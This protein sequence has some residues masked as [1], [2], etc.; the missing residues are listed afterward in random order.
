MVAILQCRAP[1]GPA[2]SQT[3]G[4][5]ECRVNGIEVALSVSVKKGLMPESIARVYRKGSV[6]LGR[7]W[8]WLSGPTNHLHRARGSD[9]RACDRFI[10][11]PS[12]LGTA[13]TLRARGPD[14]NL[15]MVRKFEAG[16]IK[17]ET[18]RRGVGFNTKD[19]P[20]N[21][22]RSRIPEGRSIQE[23]TRALALTRIETVLT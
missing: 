7:W 18:M 15:G 13:I 22:K 1:N 11:V 21:R 2:V 4:C 8:W 3:G 12:S 17:E 5:I 14:P 16:I 6:R 20:T 9:P 23:S 10:E 19:F